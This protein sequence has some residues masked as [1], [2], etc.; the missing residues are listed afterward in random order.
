MTSSSSS[1][2]SSSGYI[3]PPQFRQRIEQKPQIRRYISYNN[4]NEI[5]SS[6]PLKP[7]PSYLRP[8]QTTATSTEN[9]L[10]IPSQNHLSNII[11][12][13][14]LLSSNG[15]SASLID[16]SSIDKLSSK[17][18]HYRFI[19]PSNH[20]HILKEEPEIEQQQ[21]QQFQL[22]SI[23]SDQ[24]I[25]QNQIKSSHQIVKPTVIIPSIPKS[26][27]INRLIET[28]IHHQNE[29]SAFKPHRSSKTAISSQIKRT[30]SIQKPNMNV[31]ITNSHLRQQQSMPQFHQSMLNLSSPEPIRKTRYEPR[32]SYPQKQVYPSSSSSRTIIPE[33][34]LPK[35]ALPANNHNINNN[36]LH[37]TYPYSSFISPNTGKF[38]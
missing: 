32:I 10:I 2:S 11:K 20:N 33:E 6:S 8:V 38:Y 1:S 24:K 28:N 18:P 13:T 12:K 37:N 19:P 36:N 14:N 9:L 34:S 26:A 5:P 3:P 23:S 22:K 17:R 30:E 31:G 4:L 25:F 35:W 29:N 16:L 15:A 21:Q 27:P 7:K